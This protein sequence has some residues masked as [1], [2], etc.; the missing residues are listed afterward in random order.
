MTKTFKIMASAIALAAATA[1]PALA[2]RAA[3]VAAPVVATADVDGAVQ[4]SA[5]FTLAAS[6]I[7]TTYAAQINNR[8]VRA[9]ALQAELTTLR[10]AAI[11]EQ[12]RTPQNAA[13][14]QAA[15]TAFQTRQQAAEQELQTLSAPI[16]LAVTYVREQITLKLS[17]AVRAAT[18][19]RRV[20]V[21][22]N[23]EAVIWRAETADLTPAIVTELNRLVPNVAIVPPEGYQPGMLLR[24]QQANA[25]TA[26]VTATP[27]VPQTR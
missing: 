15:V 2:Q 26:P 24:A 17:D 4:Q 18:T 14:L 20:D 27:A 22:L 9:Q 6:Q 21:L 25:A 5:A 8:T 10:T 7:Q 16:D 1:T 19:A 23:N 11:A 3:A 13:A 12:G